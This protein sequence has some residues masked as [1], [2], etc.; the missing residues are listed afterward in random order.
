MLQNKVRTFKNSKQ[1]I[2][3]EEEKCSKVKS[4]PVQN[5]IPVKEIY[6]G[7]IITED[8][9]YVKII[10]VLPINFNLRS[11]EEQENIISLFSSWLRVA[12][13]K[14][15]FKIITR[16]A[17]T[18][19]IISNVRAAT[20]A[21][22][23]PK[24]RELAKNYINFIQDLSGTEALTRRF[25][26]VFEYEKLTNR[27]YTKD[28]I[29]EDM[30]NAALK[31]RAGLNNCGNE[32]VVPANE[33]FFQAE[34]LYICFNRVSCANEQFSDRVLRVTKDTMRMQGLTEGIDDYP[35]IPVCD[36]IA[37][38]G[39][40]LTH[41]DYIICDGSYQSVFLIESD[42]YPTKVHGGWMSTLIETGDGVD[43]DIMLQKENR[44][45]AKRRVAL[46]LKLTRIKAAGRSDVD[47]DYEEI[48]GAIQSAKYIKTC[49]SNGEDLYKMGIF[50]TVSA[51]TLEELEKR[52][53]YV[54]DYLYSQDLTARQIHLRMEDAF[55]T[56]A[57]LL[58]YKKELMD[59]AGRNVMTS[60]VASTYPFTSCEICDEN[61]IVLGVN[62]RYSSAVNIDIFNTKK[63]KNANMAI[64]GTTGSGKTYTELL[65]AMRMRI[66]GIQTFI[67]SPDKSHEFR[68]ACEH[69]GGSFIRISPG[70]PSCINIMEIRPMQSPIAELLDG[71]D[72][73]S[74]DSWLAQ[75]TAQLLI[76]FHLLISDLTNEE[77]Q[78]V[79]EAIIR[80]YNFFNI[81]HDND[82][83]FNAVT[84][85]LKPMPIIGDLY[86]VLK[87]NADTKRVANILAKFV[88]GSAQSFNQQTNVDL[89]NKFIVFDLQQ[90]TGTMKSVGMFIVMDFLWTRIKANRTE[91]KAVFID[92]GWQLIGAS[93][94]THAADFVYRIFKIIR[95]YGGSAIF[96]TQDISD[97][98]AFKGGQYGKAI[99]SNSK[100]K[101]VLG[102]EQQEAKCVKD[103]L[104]LTKNEMRSIINFHRGEGLICANN[105]KVPVFIRASDQEDRLITTDPEQL[106]IIA[107]EM[108]D[109]ANRQEK[110]RQQ[111]QS[112]PA[113]DYDTKQNTAVVSLDRSP[114]IEEAMEQ[115]KVVD[116][117]PVEEE[118]ALQK[119]AEIAMQARMSAQAMSQLTDS[120]I[121]PED[122]KIGLMDETLMVKT[123]DADGYWEEVAIE[124]QLSNSIK[125][126][127]LKHLSDAD[128]DL[129][130]AENLCDNNSNAE[131][132]EEEKEH[133]NHFPTG[134]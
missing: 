95:G 36:Y 33:D 120:E 77:E 132:I 3:K 41:A 129:D 5:E 131:K 92:E 81:T 37:P 128:S 64:L 60:G 84:G 25:F 115:K 80:T 44:T 51:D 79:D 126:P 72:E 47:D 122:K 30:K 10:E 6:K 32:V 117:E 69:I 39:L 13:I 130:S 96:A 1:G 90:L 111:T 57:P 20:E 74:N 124:A 112:E 68:R 38:R 18:N 118:S 31:I 78:L 107:S 114:A 93:A 53:E 19:K 113:K 59:I 94:D 108:Q 27:K 87:E 43:I 83:L 29:A 123:D 58:N 12:P 11:F 15:Q 23:H 8:D 100:I 73:D 4:G 17:D 26:L 101:I 46:K 45:Q 105:N 35:D 50:I 55:Q 75:K 86:D 52:K 66:Q 110:L 125:V 67:I 71:I 99:I 119:E 106:R 61:G 42:G 133:V 127:G 103:V 70:S 65:M 62:R 48:E 98:F 134:F 40:D 91:R 97:L 2:Q 102:L 82:S 28:E 63:Y 34:C 85:E 7:M 54:Y 88:T 104:Q 116:D 76:F 56:V 9:R 24:C 22:D 109:E 121:L 16:R 14:I 49:L 21:E 89:Q